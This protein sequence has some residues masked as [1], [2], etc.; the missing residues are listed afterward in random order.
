V[1]KRIIDLAVVALSAPL[2]MPLLVV[3]AL[4]VRWRIGR[5]VLFRQPRPGLNGRLFTILK[6]RTMIDAFDA[7]GHPLPDPERL[8]A[9][10]QFLRSTSLDELPSILNLLRG[11]MTLVGPRP[12][13]PEYLPLYSPEQARRHQVKPGL[14]GW[15]QIN[16]RNA[17][18]WDQK[19]TLDVWY[20]DHRSFLLDL[21]ILV[22]TAFKVLRRDGITHQNSPTA[23]R[24]TGSRR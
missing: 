17:L 19:F 16:G 4:L 6:F 20:V 21:K 14:T 24:F 1:L 15:A 2:W 11:D 18:E 13:L 10:G 8:T 23:P 9:F 7:D 5:P 22:L 12:L 3:V